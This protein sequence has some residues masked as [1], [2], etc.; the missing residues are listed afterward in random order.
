MVVNICFLCEIMYRFVCITISK[1]T[2]L[3]LDI[4][5]ASYYNGSSTEKSNKIVKAQLAVLST[6]GTGKHVGK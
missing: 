4:M 1:M 6:N 5:D 2:F 3:L